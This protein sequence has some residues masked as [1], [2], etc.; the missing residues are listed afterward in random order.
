MNKFSLVFTF[1]VILFSCSGILA[2]DTCTNNTNIS[3][4]EFVEEEDVSGV[5][6][7]LF[8]IRMNL[9]DTAVVMSSDL[10]AVMTYESFGSIPTPVN[11]TFEVFD[12]DENLL[13]SKD[14]FIIVTVEE[15]RRYEFSDLDLP[16]GE[17]E[18]VFT[19]L[20]NVDVEDKFRSK[21]VVEERG[22]PRI[23]GGVIAEFGKNVGEFVRKNY[24]VFLVLLLVLVVLLIVFWRRIWGRCVVR[25]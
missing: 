14:G 23:T 20:Y 12:L 17:Y 16:D 9:E 11:L 18:F 15:V 7:E 25:S 8:D 1:G 10:R 21:F 3:V 5:P 6:E 19:T 4:D 2:L 13:Y 24:V 22:I